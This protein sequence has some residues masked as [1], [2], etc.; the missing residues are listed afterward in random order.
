MY[1]T[2]EQELSGILLTKAGSCVRCTG[3]LD[4]LLGS[5]SGIP[6]L[7]AHQACC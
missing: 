4:R 3:Q 1:P 6:H 2:D 7:S 5:R